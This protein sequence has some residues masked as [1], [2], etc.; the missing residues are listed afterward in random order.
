[1]PFFLEML[2]LTCYYDYVN[3]FVSDS[4]LA[5]LFAAGV[6]FF[7]LFKAESPPDLI[8]ICDRLAVLIGSDPVCQVSEEICKQISSSEPE[9]SHPVRRY[10]VI[11]CRVFNRDFSVVHR[12]SLSGDP[13]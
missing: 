3:V 8:H 12:T 9:F 6:L 2:P 4:S 13:Y 10:A 7:Y 1:M 11:P 5:H